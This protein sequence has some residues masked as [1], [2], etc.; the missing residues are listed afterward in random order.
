MMMAIRGGFAASAA[1]GT[2][3]RTAGPVRNKR[4]SAA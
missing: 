1:A 4:R 2:G 3:M